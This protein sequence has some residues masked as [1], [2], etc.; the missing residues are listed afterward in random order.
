VLG[1]TGSIENMRTLGDIVAVL[2]VFQSGFSE[3]ETLLEATEGQAS[4][5]LVKRKSRLHWHRRE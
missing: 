5:R 1:K 4:M 3:L 2:K